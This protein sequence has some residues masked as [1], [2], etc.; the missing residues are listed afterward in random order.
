MLFFKPKTWILTAVIAAGASGLI[1]FKTIR[2]LVKATQSELRSGAAALVPARIEVQT[3]LEEAREKIPRH[4]A[5]TR[6][7]LKSCRGETTRHKQLLAG[8]LE[9]KK[10]LEKDLQTLA[11]AL[12]AGESVE[13]RGRSLSVDDVRAEAAR[14]MGIRK[15]REA[16][17][18]H[19]RLVLERLND[20]CEKIAKRLAEAEAAASEFSEQAKSASEKLVLLEMAQRAEALSR[21]IGDDIP[22]PGGGTGSLAA[23]NKQ[24]DMKLDEMSQRERLGKMVT[25]DT[26]QAEGRRVSVLEQLR[27]L[28]PRSTETTTAVD[29]AAP[30]DEGK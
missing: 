12:H 25:D 16:S 29:T 11:A 8:D 10:L 23:I 28:Y 19:R 6:A 14:L 2:N 4:L 20:Q 5:V 13:L 9:C 3:A 24:L 27:N 17:I 15:R 21:S 1:G 30:E 18:R 26:Y 22:V 7:A